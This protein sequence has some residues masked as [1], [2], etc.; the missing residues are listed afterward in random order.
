MISTIRKHMKSKGFQIII[1]ITLF[2]LVGGLSVIPA[3]KNLFTRQKL[4]SIATVN[5]Y[6]ISLN[7]FMRHYIPLVQF[8]KEAKKQYGENA[9]LILGIWGIDLQKK[10]E[11]ITL[12]SLVQEKTIQSEADSLKVK[13]SK[14]YIDSKLQ[15]AF[16]VRNSLSDLIPAQAYQDGKLNVSIL[17]S[18]LK[19]QGISPSEFEDILYKKLERNLF[20]QLMQGA[21]YIPENLMKEQYMQLF[22]KRKYGILTLEVKKYLENVQEEKLQETDIENFFQKHKELYRVPERRFG[23]LWEFSPELYNVIVSEK[24]I[25]QFYNKNKKDFITK[26]DERDIKRILI[27]G[28]TE[29]QALEKATELS[30]KLKENPE[31]FD[32]FIEKESQASDKQAKI[33]IKRGKKDSYEQVVFSLYEENAVSEPVKTTE[34]YEIIKVIAIRPAEY[35]KKEEVKNEI[36]AKVKSEKFRNIFNTDA[37]RILNQSVDDSTVFENFIK[38]KHAVKKNIGP[39]EKNATVLSNKLFGL[40]KVEEKAFYQDEGKGYLVQLDKIEKS[41]LPKLSDIKDKVIQD[42]YK[43]KAFNLMK[44]DLNSISKMSDLKEAAKQFNATFVYTDWIDPKNENSLK[45]IKEKKL[46]EQKL[47]S[48]INVGQVIQHIALENSYIIKLYEIEPFD[49]ENFKKNKHVVELS[50][51]KTQL[52]N[53]FEDISKKLEHDAKV[54]VNAALLKQ[55]SRL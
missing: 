40:N 51:R 10:P 54:Q 18:Y 22:S 27:K 5:N 55:V 25:D 37:R 39:I 30:L 50:L 7:E 31:L 49:E 45:E 34:G 28:A 4:N 2:S 35:K 38:E 6:E 12:Q 52:K 13:I 15:D 48:L 36:I 8:I 24:E 26:A 29:A 11:D 19:R 20:L 44:K 42:I 9:D 21:L 41:Y 33:T 3:L 32:E 43:E 53:V 47:F 14:E 17:E 46:P 23:S 1:W 16:F